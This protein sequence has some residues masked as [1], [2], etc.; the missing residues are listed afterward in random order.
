MSFPSSLLPAFAFFP[1][2]ATV[3]GTV[4]HTIL[5]DILSFFYLSPISLGRLFTLAAPILDTVVA[6]ALPTPFPSVPHNSIWLF[7]IHIINFFSHLV[8]CP[9]YKVKGG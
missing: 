6:S 3:C 5:A 2:S 9:K 4:V 7:Y 8:Q 1:L